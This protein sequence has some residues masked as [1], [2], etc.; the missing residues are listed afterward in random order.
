VFSLVVPNPKSAAHPMATAMLI[1]IGLG[2]WGAKKKEKK[3]RK[4]N[5]IFFT[6]GGTATAADCLVDLA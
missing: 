1:V 6:R 5:K 4:N 2:P 3:K